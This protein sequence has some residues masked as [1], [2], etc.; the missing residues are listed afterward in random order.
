MLQ[1]SGFCRLESNSDALR[2]AYF[3]EI[4]C[5]WTHGTERKKKQ[6]RRLKALKEK[7]KQPVLKVV[8][9]IPLIFLSNF[10]ANSFGG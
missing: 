4:F 1:E 10:L 9:F 5:C 6:M 7:K 8:L 2:N 3:R